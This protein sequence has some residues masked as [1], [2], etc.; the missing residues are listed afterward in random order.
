MDPIING[1][2]GIEEQI[3]IYNG[4]RDTLSKVSFLNLLLN[5]NNINK[6]NLLEIL[7]KIYIMFQ[8]K[9][10]NLK[11]NEIMN[12]MI[13]HI[14][15]EWYHSGNL[16]EIKDPLSNDFFPRNYLNK[17]KHEKSCEKCNRI[18]YLCKLENNILFNLDD[19]EEHPL[20]NNFKDTINY[21]QETINSFQKNMNEIKTVIDTLNNFNLSLFIDLSIKH[22]SL[23]LKLNKNQNNNS[24]PENVHKIFSNFIH[25]HNLLHKQLI[26]YYQYLHGL[27]EDIKQRCTKMNDLEKNIQSIAFIGRNKQEKE[28]EKQGKEEKEE[29]EEKGEKEDVD[30]DIG[31][32][33]IEGGEVKV[34]KAKDNHQLLSFF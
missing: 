34:K 21:C 33:Y 17:S 11:E 32:L 7:Y 29:K 20:E 25:I 24:I 15:D 30:E 4:R 10:N 9:I 3:D 5:Y 2:R 26:Q 27:L 19:G 28:K 18:N 1:E 12:Q 23:Y 16:L 14:K 22:K 6:D 13:E 8:G 31:D